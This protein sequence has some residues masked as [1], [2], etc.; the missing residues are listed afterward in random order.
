MTTFGNTWA[1]DNALWRHSI[2]NFDSI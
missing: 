2:P 1:L